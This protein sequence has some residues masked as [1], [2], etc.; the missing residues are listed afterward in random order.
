M[1]LAITLAQKLA[2]TPPEVA[3]MILAMLPV[4]E[5][6]GAVPVA[7]ALYKLPVIT[8]MFWAVVGNMLPVW[9][10]LVFF[11]RGSQWLRVRSPYA[12][13]LYQKLIER[14]RRKLEANVEKYGLW[15][16]AL[17]VAIPLPMTGAWTGALAA[18]VF[19]L[20]K[21]QAFLAILVGVI[22][23][24]TIVTLLTLGATATAQ[25]LL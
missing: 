8:A 2:A 17:F 20:P 15:A 13:R 6:R 1:S 23:A 21:K 22:I 19:G 25:R 14:T 16:L 9:F 3:T 10:L 12:D 5:L 7:L 18:F 11:E 4:V 24:A